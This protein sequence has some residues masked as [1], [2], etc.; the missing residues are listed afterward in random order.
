MNEITSTTEHR[1][2]RPGSTAA[3]SNR[4]H[5]IFGREQW[6][7]EPELSRVLFDDSGLRLS[8][9][10]AE[11]RSQVVKTG[12]HRTVYRLDLPC[13][14]FYLKHYKSSDW[15]SVLRNLTLPCRA[16]RES[17][18]AA[19]VGDLGIGTIETAAVG[20]ETVGPVVTDS[21]LISREIGNTQTLQELVLRETERHA[22]RDHTDLRRQLAI[23]L[24]Q[25]AS[26]LHASGM[27]HRDFHAEN[28]LVRRDPAGFVQL[29]LIDLHAVDRYRRLSLKTIE[30]N[31]SQLNNFFSVYATK[32]D[33]LRFF[34]TYWRSLSTS[35]GSV[36]I[37]TSRRTPF[38]D[39]VR[40]T[41]EYCRSAVQ[42]AYRKGDRKWARG[43]RRL[44]IADAGSRRCRGVA[45]LGR[46]YL[47]EI[48]DDPES[49]FA[50]RCVRYWLHN[51][52]KMQLAAI[53]LTVGGS[54]LRCIARAAETPVR[55]LPIRLFRSGTSAR[56]IW[57]IG[58]ALRRRS[59][60]AQRPILYVES[61]SSQG[62]RELLVTEQ[63]ADM[64]PLAEFLAEQSRQ[65]STPQ[66]CVLVRDLTVRLA[67]EIRRFHECRF[68]HRAL[69]GDNILVSKNPNAT[70]V[71]FEGL[72]HV[73]QTLRLS[74]SRC[75]RQLAS[76]H[77]SLSENGQIRR[78]HRLRF[79]KRYLND[80]RSREWKNAWREIRRLAE[81]LA[82][83]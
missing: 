71:V 42:A 24:G 44:I 74:R 65:T 13:G 41:D 7:A 19:T 69:T 23:Q 12:P 55:P 79:L 45:E 40:R 78:S 33:R 83:S 52:A 30:R 2:P 48:R 27:L 70:Q 60:G 15:Q 39:V 57:D 20:Y 53:R 35:A 38:S 77:V 47:E 58:H 14:G 37:E 36:L 64:T 31:L 80:R 68:E 10:Q 8:E 61:P 1:R 26:R 66:S 50:P 63:L 54:P 28:I 25:L 46:R 82:A 21:Y 4:V 17:R 62:L 75:L 73:K 9:W 5:I 11:G 72:E 18:A 76:L 3:T 81:Q 34:R 43:N 22:E 59:L 32:T 6:E 29:W 56:H 16:L 51:S 67:A 49:L